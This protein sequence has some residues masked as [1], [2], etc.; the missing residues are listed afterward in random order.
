MST[1]IYN[2]Q[3]FDDIYTMEDLPNKLREQAD[4][5]EEEIRKG[6]IEFT[7]DICGIEINLDYREKEKTVIV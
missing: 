5:I 1:S 4:K 3:I 7:L 6:I 2:A